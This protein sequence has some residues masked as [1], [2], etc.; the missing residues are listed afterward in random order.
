[1]WG[2][3]F[4]LPTLGLIAILGSY[5]FAAAPGTVAELK[6]AFQ[7][8]PDDARMM[9]RWW[10]FGPAV[11]KPELEREMRAMKE[12][13]IGGFE[14]QPTYPLALDDPAHGFKNLPYLS[15]EFLEAL[16]FTGEKARELGLR[17]DLTL[18]SGWPFGGPHIPIT[19]AA[20]RLRV[21]RVPA[22]ADGSSPPAPNLAEG[23]K[24]ITQTRQDSAVLFF[25]ASRTRQTVKRPAVGAEGLVLDHY[26][27]A[28]IQN[29]L[30]TVGEPMLRALAKTPPY[31]IFSDSL[32]VYNSDWTTNFLDEFRKRRG[33][34]L[35]PYLPAL[36]GDIG[37]K[38]GAIRHDWGKTLS[39]L[40]DQNYL[41]PLRQ[42]AQQHETRFRSQSYGIPPVTLSSSSLVDLPEGE[43]TQWRHFSATRWAASASHLY[44]KPVTSSETWT[45]LH[46]PVFRATPLDMK[47]EADLHFLQGINQL[48]GHGFP[49]SPPEAGEPGW[50]FYAAAVFN[51]HNP[52]WLVMPDV[53]AYMQ[54]VSFLLRQGQ[55]ANDVALY[56]PTA[57]AFA[58]FA[59]GRDSVNQAMDGLIGQTVIPQILDAGYN[60]DFIDDGAIAHGGVPYRIL[61]LP[62]VER[63]PL[64]TMQKIDEYARKGGTVIATRRVPLLAPGLME[65]DRD[66]PRIREL[67]SALRP[68]TD[69]SRLGAE[70]HKALA[71]DVAT[72]PEIGFVHRKLG[73]A[74]VYFLANTSNHPVHAPADFRIEGLDA[75]VWDPMTGREAWAGGKRLDLIL[76]PY[77]SR[78]VVFSKERGDGPL[79]TAAPRPAPLDL[80]AGWK[81]TFAGSSQAVTMDAGHSWTE[82]DTRKY[83]SGQATYEK[84]VTYHAA[85]IARQTI[86]L[87]FGEGAP[88]TTQERRS[89]SGMRAMY[90]GPVR[91]AAVVYVN[92]KRAGSVWCAP[93][94]VD[95]SGLLKDG[96]NTIR[97][98]VANTALN[99]LAKG[100]LPD[101]RA[102]NAKYGERFQPQDMGSV[103]P[104]MSGLLGP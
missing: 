21:V 35:T 62:G 41:T 15:D 74:D 56:L 40:A 65:R 99:L 86:Y 60:F 64:A 43:G 96:E 63:I 101:Y 9:V 82:D 12:G 22:P 69:E 7:H 11:T 5:S 33:Y 18:G 3:R 39:E 28:A 92:G 51:N 24:L 72:A 30:K 102:L 53:T 66:T 70:L 104:V 84:T 37:E 94:Q 17:M 75:T 25:I 67:A 14:V 36:A 81:V 98:V 71:A 91:E 31:A 52:W 87:T 77:E 32:E 47:A 83:F 46:S 79:L 90:E 42:W 103:Q 26:D 27:L 80:S 85:D 76:A 20:G 19:Q 4:R 97:I 34:D 23:E 1:M 55:P 13:G 16:R 2:R 6:Q 59:P 78:I 48:V 29:H 8:P 58:G 61:I 57:D 10:W 89:G 88:V 50:R 95:V 68:L 54:R 93:Y 44:G 45:W 73:F 49:Y 38:T 100:P